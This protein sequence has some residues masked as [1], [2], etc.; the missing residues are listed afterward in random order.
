MFFYGTNVSNTYGF[1]PNLLYPT[2]VQKNP[3]NPISTIATQ[4]LLKRPRI[5]EREVPKQRKKIKKSV[6]HNT[7]TSPKHLF[8]PSHADLY[9]QKWLDI[10]ARDHAIAAA[11]ALEQYV[12]NCR[13]QA[14]TP[15][16]VEQHEAYP[17]P[18]TIEFS[19]NWHELTLTAD[20]VVQLLT[21]SESPSSPLKA[22]PQNNPT[23]TDCWHELTLGPDEVVQL[24]TSS[25]L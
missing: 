11:I 2:L 22:N 12:A 19:E 14:L 8:A 9:R 17:H 7:R 3:P 15:M 16:Y 10:M 23:I 4:N 13:L 5:D 24:L 20:E 1:R 21:L 25:E 18:Q 6:T